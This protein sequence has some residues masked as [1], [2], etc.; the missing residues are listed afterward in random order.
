MALGATRPRMASH[1]IVL[2]DEGSLELGMTGDTLVAI[3][4][5]VDLGVLIRVRVV[6][7]AALHPSLGNR[8]V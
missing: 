8:M 6:A 5:P 4:G 3:G 2:E 1:R 7:I